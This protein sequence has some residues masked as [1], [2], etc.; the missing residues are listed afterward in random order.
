ML[1]LIRL[2]AQP[3]NKL[4]VLKPTFILGV[5]FAILQLGTE[6]NTELPHYIVIRF[7]SDMY[8]D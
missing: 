1:I 8:S 2:K 3:F 6:N 5:N 7:Y 4:I